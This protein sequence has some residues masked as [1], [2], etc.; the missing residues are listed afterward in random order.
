MSELHDP[1]RKALADTVTALVERHGGPS[2]V[3]VRVGADRT[4]IHRWMRGDI[5]IDKL[6]VLAEKLEEPIA[7]RFGPEI[8]RDAPAEAGAAETMLRLWLGTEAPPWAKELTRQITGEVKALRGEAMEEAVQ[9]E[10]RAAGLEL[11]KQIHAE[12]A[13]DTARPSRSKRAKPGE[14]S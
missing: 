14:P 4:T 2:K 1:T 3:S 8:E 7:I 11:R 9:Q 5:G 12:L 6:G 10:V 13:R